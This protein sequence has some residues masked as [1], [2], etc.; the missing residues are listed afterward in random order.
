MRPPTIKHFALLA[1]ALVA[2]PHAAQA[3]V[4]HDRLCDPQ[5]ED[6]RAP[7]L[8]L[9]ANERQG[10][11]V[12]FWF[13]TDARYTTAIIKRFQAGVPV[14]VI[15]DERANVSKPK[16][17]TYLQILKDA[18]IPMRNKV[19]GGIL[20]WKMMLFH[21]QNV[22]EFSKAN[23]SPESFVAT[24]PGVDWFDEAVFFTRDDRVTNTFRTK[25]DNLWVDTSSLA[26]Y[27]NITAPLVRRYPVYEPDPPLSWLNFPPSNDFA[28]KAI[29]RYNAE[30][31]QI[32]ALVYRVTDNRHADAMI[33]A[34]KRGVRVRIITELHE[35]RDAKKLEHAY[36]LDRMYM[37]SV[38]GRRIE[39]KQRQHQGLMHELG[40]VLHGLGEAIF[41][42]SNM[43]P[44]SADFQNEHNLFY[45]PAVN[46]VLDSGETFFQWFADQFE[47]KWNHS[48]AF[49]D[50]QPLPPS[51]PVYSAP[52]NFATGVSTNVTLRWDGGNWAYTYDIY[53]GT[54]STPP[55]LVKD[56]KLGSPTTGVQESYPVNLSPGTTYYWRIVGKTIA[57]KAS[58]GPI[59]SFTTAGI[60][61]GSAAYGGTPA[62]LPGTIQAVNFDNGGSGVAY[63]DTTAGNTGGVYRTDTNVDIGQVSSGYYVGWT[64]P[65]EWLQY[66]VNVAT[67]GTY[68]LEALVANQGTG[69]KFRVDVDGVDKTGT[70]DVPNTGGWDTW[71]TTP[72]RA[73]SLTA[74]QHKVRLW[75]LTANTGAS[76]VGN[77]RWLRFTQQ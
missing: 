73:I 66:T 4:Q 43:S 2:V 41:G 69:A 24:Q 48:T 53:L 21:G 42:S 9:I 13:M 18:G 8:T 51:T 45:S 27:A 65:G 71:Q 28:T 39:M 14:R 16:N 50:F 22:V 6:C 36:N 55:L 31:T 44:T 40:I 38:D 32:D 74:G 59:R 75:F 52:S 70:L 76:G 64:R 19:N 49:V 23:Y 10:I 33:A 46:I 37:A 54:S 11:D 29:S 68:T 1:F 72:P 61:T 3:Q 57:Q 62:A 12:A 20:H 30:P 34:L 7:L 5:L 56:V 25:F 58:S 77:F 26:N 35:Y 63:Y 15:M 17:A 47:G 67:G 60:G